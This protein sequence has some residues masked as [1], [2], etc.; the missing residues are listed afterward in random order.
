[1]E[2]LEGHDLGE[3]LRARRLQSLEAKLEVMEQICEGVGFAHQKGMVHRDLK[4]SN[5]YVAE[6]RIKIL[7]F[8]LARW[9]EGP[10]TT[11]GVAGTPQYM[12]PEQVRGEA[13]DS[14]SDVFSLGAMFYEMLADQRCFP[15]P[16]LHAI[17][18]QVLQREPESLRTLKPD[19]PLLAELVV[20]KSLDKEQDARFADGQELLEAIRLLRQVVS[21]SLAEADAIQS[22]GLYGD[23]SPVHSDPREAVAGSPAQAMPQPGPRAET[24]SMPFSGSPGSMPGSAPSQPPV[25]VRGNDGAFGTTG[26]EGA[27][28]LL[29]RERRR[30]GFGGRPQ[31]GADVARS[32]AGMPGFRTFTSV[33]AGAD[34]PPAVCA[35]R[36]W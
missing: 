9:A 16:T 31:I 15:A 21:G 2:Y 29:A 18:F 35:S 8:G 1:M 6:G 10:K 30:Q 19:M 34:A 24:T 26:G 28:R 27:C 22:L 32:C 13:V 23:A 12:S 11:L 33:A 17:L 36:W 7:D 3:L 20:A 25:S 5:I 4:P 14:R